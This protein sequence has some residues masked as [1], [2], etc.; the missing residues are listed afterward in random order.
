MNRKT[1][2]LL[3][4]TL[5]GFAMLMSACGGTPADSNAVN[6]GKSTGTTV[7]SVAPKISVTDASGKTSASVVIGNNITLTSSETDVTWTTTDAKVATVN[8]G[9]VTAVSVGQAV[10]KASKEGFKDGT[11]TITVT[12]PAATATLHFEDADHFSADGWWENSSRGPGAQPVY[13]KSS[14]SDGTCIGYFGEGDKETLSFTSNAAVKAE[15]VV[16]MGH[17]SSFES[18]ATIM[19]AKFNNKDIS[20]TNVAYTSDSDGQGGYSFAEVSFGEVDLVN[21]DNALEIGLL[22]NAP[23]LDDLLIYAASAATIQVKQ[24]PAKTTL[25]VTNTAEELTIVEGNT[26]TLKPNATGITFT[27]SAES[28]AT[29]DQNG[30]VTAVAKGTANISMVKAGYISARVAITVN[31]KIVDGTFIVEAESG[32]CGGAAITEESEKVQTKTSSGG[33][34]Y[35]TNWSEGETV[36]WEFT[37]AKAGAFKMSMDARHTSYNGAAIDLSTAIEVKLNGTVI[38]VEGSV[39]GYSF[40]TYQLANVTLAANNR[41][42]VKNISGAPAIDFFKFVPQA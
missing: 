5:A 41:L 26:V 13:S 1:K 28:V 2:G 6:P 25:A 15:L 38:A 31:E 18:L 16:T 30:V 7:K 37:S 14:A 35:L 17:N 8:G 9:V 40:K 29:V 19:T 27:S 22:G 10:I 34:T 4:L 21:G 11:F 36:V 24:A 33:Q 39:S 23:Y 12:R 42:E 32:T 3:G 20:L